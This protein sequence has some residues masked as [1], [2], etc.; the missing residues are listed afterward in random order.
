MLRRVIASL[1]LTEAWTRLLSADTNIQ[2]PTL[3][4]YWTPIGRSQTNETIAHRVCD[5]SAIIDFALSRDSAVGPLCAPDRQSRMPRMS[6]LS[7]PE[8]M[9]V[10]ENPANASIRRRCSLRIVPDSAKRRFDFP[11]HPDRFEICSTVGLY[12]CAQK[13]VYELKPDCRSP[14]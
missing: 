9:D 2:C 3:D 10:L 7:P 1:L 11:D 5:R 14:F 6:S 8:M 4:S 13:R 12:F